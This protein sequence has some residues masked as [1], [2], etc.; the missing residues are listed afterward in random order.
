METLAKNAYALRTTHATTS[1]L[2]K[3]LKALSKNKVSFV[4]EITKTLIEIND[5]MKEALN[6]SSS[7]S[8]NSLKLFQRW[9]AEILG[10]VRKKEE[11]DTLHVLI[12]SSTCLSNST[13]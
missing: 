6:Q 2:E 11:K 3:V 13:E 12:K 9:I 1:L 10:N 4:T 8:E 7:T 5:Y